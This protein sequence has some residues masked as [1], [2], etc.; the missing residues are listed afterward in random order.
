[1]ARDYVWQAL[2]DQLVAVLGTHPF[3]YLYLGTTLVRLQEE[4][5]KSSKIFAKVYIHIP[6]VE[7]SLLGSRLSLPLL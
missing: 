2:W 7:H 5:E 3:T 4:E 6:G 1:M